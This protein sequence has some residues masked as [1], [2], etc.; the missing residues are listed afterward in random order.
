MVTRGEEVAEAEVNDLDVTG[1]ADEYVLN[2]EIS[3]DNAVAMAVVE[4]ARDLSA[5]L[6]GLLLLKLAV[7]DDIV[8][9]LAAVDV[10]E[11]H[12]PMVVGSDDIAQA[13]D[14]RVA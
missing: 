1:L 11:E 7:R 14:V 9:H 2:L 13:A 6:P 5:E 10:L 8:E 12:V 3:V 4:S